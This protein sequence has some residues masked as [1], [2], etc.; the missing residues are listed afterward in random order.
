MEIPDT[1]KILYKEY[2]NV[3]GKTFTT[4]RV[5]YTERYTIWMRK[6]CLMQLVRKIKRKQ[7]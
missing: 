7:P 5:I 1:V 3:Q 6:F 4:I 2:E